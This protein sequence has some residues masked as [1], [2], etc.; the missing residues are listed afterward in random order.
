MA[1]PVKMTA[2]RLALFD[3]LVALILDEGFAHLTLDD[4]A[5]RCTARSPR[6]TALRT[7][8]NSWSALPRFHFFR[9]ATEQVE[10]SVAGAV[11]ARDRIRRYLEAVGEQ[12]RPASPR[13]ME[14]LA[15][16]PAVRECTSA[17]RGSRP[18]ASRNSSPRGCGGGVAGRARRLRRGRR[19]RRDG[20][21]SAAPGGGR[22]RSGR[23]PG[24]RGIG[25]P[26][27]P[28]TLI[29]RSRIEPGRERSDGMGHPLRLEVIVGSVRVQRFAPRRH[30]LVRGAGPARGE[31][32]T[33][34]L[35]LADA[36]LPGSFAHP[37]SRRLHRAYRERGPRSSS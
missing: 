31:F 35:D 33:A 18:G 37:R 12:L 26:A 9:G 24:V 4:L 20:A 6:C 36:S 32:D 10:A 13:F 21:D 22:G 5:A 23:R 1:T 27:D 15:A 34:V 16:D 14:D 25:D 7:A 19:R 17:T 11:D 8:R 2:R 3:A 29:G 30:R 28:W